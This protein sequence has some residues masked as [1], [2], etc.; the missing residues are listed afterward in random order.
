MSVLPSIRS[1][2]E[3]YDP[4]FHRKTHCPDNVLAA[5][6]HRTVTPSSSAV[7]ACVAQQRERPE[8]AGWGQEL[9]SGLLQKSGQAFLRFRSETAWIDFALCG[10]ND[11]LPN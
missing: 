3:R 6:E 7:L 2:I 1:R 9:R 10:V 8:C 4:P 11:G 5:C